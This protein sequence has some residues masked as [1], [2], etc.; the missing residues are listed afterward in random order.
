MGFAAVL[1]SS[2]LGVLLPVA[3]EQSQESPDQ[4]GVLAGQGQR[5]PGAAL[6][7]LRA[8]SGTWSW[9]DGQEACRPQGVGPGPEG[10]TA[11][12]ALGPAGGCSRAVPP[13]PPA[14]QGREGAHRLVEVGSSVPPCTRGHRA[15]PGAVEANAG[16]SCYSGAGPLPPAEAEGHRHAQGAG[17]AGAGAV[18]GWVVPG[19]VVLLSL[20]RP[21]WPGEGSLPRGPALLWAV[22]QARMGAR[23]AGSLMEWPEWLW[24][25]SMAPGGGSGQVGVSPAL[26][27]GEAP[28]PGQGGGAAL[29]P[30]PSSPLHCWPPW[31]S[32]LPC[33][34][35]WGAVFA[36]LCY[37]R[38]HPG[39]FLP[40]KP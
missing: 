28:H 7:P 31:V 17:L 30:T 13:A 33:P 3:R 4:R 39:Q 21:R 6:W 9:A 12:C 19:W 2:P 26:L 36:C 5:E 40:R 15:R 27:L 29:H 10:R 8:E 22:A 25:G 23:V 24:V 32:A 16:L 20:P 38:G 37:P 35:C 11:L 34:C 14:L 18:S 1:S